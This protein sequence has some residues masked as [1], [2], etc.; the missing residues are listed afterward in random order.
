MYAILRDPPAGVNAR[1]FSAE[2]PGCQNC[3]GFGSMNRSPQR[4]AAQT[5]ETDERDAFAPPSRSYKLF[6]LEIA[7]SGVR[8]FPL[9]CPSGQKINVLRPIMQCCRVKICPVGPNQRLHLKINLDL[10]E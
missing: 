2:S 6:R 10:I 8:E 9:P 3:H 7:V 4:L 5:R 1:E